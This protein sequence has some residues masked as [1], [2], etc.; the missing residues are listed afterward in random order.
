MFCAHRLQLCETIKKITNE[1]TGQPLE[2]LRM[3]KCLPLNCPSHFFFAAGHGTF[4]IREKCCKQIVNFM[5]APIIVALHKQD[6]L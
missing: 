6:Q 5:L 1:S 3:T 4:T 2:A